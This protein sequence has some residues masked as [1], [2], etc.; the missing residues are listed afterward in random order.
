MIIF[1]VYGC[2]C[3]CVYSGEY[4]REVSPCPKC[5]AIAI[6]LLDGQKPD[7]YGACEDCGFVISGMQYHGHGAV[8]DVLALGRKYSKDIK[9]RGI[10]EKFIVKT[11]T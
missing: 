9:C 10:P 8:L 4:V 6:R 11:I 5:A 7:T 2:K 1:P 3:G